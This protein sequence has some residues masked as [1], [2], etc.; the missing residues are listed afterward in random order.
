MLCFMHQVHSYTIEVMIT[1]IKRMH[2]K[3][4]EKRFI[5]QKIQLQGVLV[6]D[7]GAEFCLEADHQ[8]L[9]LA[10]EKKAF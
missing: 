9:F 1:I 10:L 7:A 2:C 6:A 4:A 3:Q 8:K 5:F